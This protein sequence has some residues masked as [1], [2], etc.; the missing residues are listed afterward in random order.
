MNDAQFHKEREGLITSSRAPAVLGLNKRQSPHAVWRVITGREPEPDLSDDPAIRRGNLLED[1]TLDFAAEELG[2]VRQDAEFRKHEC[3]FLGDHADA[4]LHEEIEVE[5]R[6]H[7]IGPLKAIAEGKSCALGVAKQYGE[8]NTDEVAETTLV[9]CHFHNLHWPE[10]PV[11]VAP[12]IVGGYRFDFRLYRIDRDPKFMD[13]L[14][15][16]LGDWWQAHVV[17]DEPPP[18]EAQDAAWVGNHWPSHEENK[19]LMATSEAA[20]LAE[21]YMDAR[22][23]ETEAKKRKTTAATRLKALLGEHC[24][25]LTSDIKV[26]FTKNKDSEVVDWQ[27][28]AELFLAKTL[29][30]ARRRVLAEHTKTKRGNRPL[31][32]TPRGRQ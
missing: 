22:T 26:Q 1:L 10:S 14:L 32:V 25:M 31:L 24:G 11:C 16:E 8:Q 19:W 17:K 3:G 9:Q 21:D 4:T 5:P 13:T 6:V 15:N 29:P 30:G 27:G 18:L 12:V 20:R 7:A 2:L 28:I 23:A